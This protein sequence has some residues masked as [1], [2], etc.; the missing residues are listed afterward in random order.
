[1]PTNDTDDLETE[2]PTRTPDLRSAMVFALVAVAMGSLWWFSWQPPV[3][4]LVL[5]V[6]L[7][8]LSWYD[9]H[10]FRL[11]NLLTI[12]LVLASGAL[13]MTLPSGWVIDH[14]IGGAVGLLFF[15]ILNM[16]YKAFR[17]RSGIGLGD[18][19][20]FAG[21]GLWLGWFNLPFVLLTASLAALVVVSLFFLFT[22]GE[23]RKQVV[24]KPIPFGVFL[25]F[26]AWVSWIFP[27]IW[28]Y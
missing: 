17:G 16:V 26:G 15:P 13:L 10:Y 20:L 1:M 19:K 8:A 27:Q 2:L 24:K 25:C 3:F 18:A 22:H 23:N 14:V 28:N 6:N 9:Y 21:I 4:S 11:P 12:A 7:L 5:F